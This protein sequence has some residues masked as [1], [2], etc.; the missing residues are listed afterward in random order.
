M[1][2]RHRGY[3]ERDRAAICALRQRRCLLVRT[4]S[5]KARLWLLG[6]GLLVLYGLTL[7]YLLLRPR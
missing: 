7:A 4:S 1:H 6:V 2:H 3:W 5:N